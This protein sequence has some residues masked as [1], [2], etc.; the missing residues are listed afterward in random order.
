MVLAA[1]QWRNTSKAFLKNRRYYVG[2]VL[3]ANFLIFESYTHDNITF[4]KNWPLHAG[5]IWR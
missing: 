4:A 3:S 2:A 5:A 1:T